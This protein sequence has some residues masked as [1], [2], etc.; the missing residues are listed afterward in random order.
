VASS[1][2]VVQSI[3]FRGDANE[4]A[5]AVRN[6]L[7]AAIGDDAVAGVRRL[8]G[9][10]QPLGVGPGALA[11]A[12]IVTPA[13]HHLVKRSIDWLIE[14]VNARWV[15]HRE[16]SGLRPQFYVLVSS[17]DREVELKVLATDSKEAAKAK[18][19][20]FGDDLALAGLEIRV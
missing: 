8:D 20:K 9:G 12:L 10:G 14:W 16:S 1:D 11:L 2:L 17:G 18:I 13:V 15:A 3:G 6:G 4:A 7:A 19:K 5:E